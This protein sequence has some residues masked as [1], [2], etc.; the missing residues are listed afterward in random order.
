MKKIGQIIKNKNPFG[1]TVLDE[2]TVF[3]IFAKVIQEEFG[4]QGN[5]NLSPDF[6]KNGKIFV[7]TESSN[8]A[9][10]L[11]LNRQKIIREI[12]KELGTE[13]VKEIKLSK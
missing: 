4:K 3:Y 8:W 5:A 10:E 13:E 11:W 9:N 2:K 12:N 6:Y 1:K 7:K